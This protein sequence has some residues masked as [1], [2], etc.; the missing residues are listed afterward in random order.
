MQRLANVGAHLS[1]LRGAQVPAAAA[2]EVAGLSHVYAGREGNVPA[3]EDIA[4]T[5]GAG[6]FVVIVGPSGCGKT[7]L[8]MML[9]GLRAQSRG[10]ILCQGSPIP[11]PDP[12]RID[13]DVV[14]LGLAFGL[15]HGLG[16]KRYSCGARG[17]A[18]LC[19]GILLLAVG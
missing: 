12:R 9:A 8:L 16:H 5:V 6:R 7:S 18:L 10:T 19:G 2:I 13:V 3:L 4:L 15:S 11:N 1:D 17:P 14:Q